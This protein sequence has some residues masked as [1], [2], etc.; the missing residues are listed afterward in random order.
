ML[1]PKL[2]SS[3]GSLIG[4]HSKCT[5][6]NDLEYPQ[7]SLEVSVQAEPRASVDNPLLV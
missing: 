3:N 7:M 4:S 6:N 2:H 1:M 5:N